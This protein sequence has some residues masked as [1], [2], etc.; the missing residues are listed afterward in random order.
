VTPA[1]LDRVR[2]ECKALVTKRAM[3]SAGT[4]LVPI[5]MID[6]VVDVNILTK[7]LPEISRRFG[8][9]HEAVERMEPRRAEQVLVVATSLG[10]SAIGRAV[11]RRI[12][13]AILRRV[14]VRLLGGQVAKFVPFLGQAT[15][16]GI[17]FGAMK[18]AGDRHVDDCYE[19]AKRTLLA[20]A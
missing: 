7:L 4:A 3:V 9:D 14:G 12:V 5:P 13:A 1:D 8:L 17:S 2:D 11:T 19:T 20:T 16:A 15:A 10:N 6:L 18:L